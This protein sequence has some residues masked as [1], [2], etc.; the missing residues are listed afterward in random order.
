MYPVAVPS[1]LKSPAPSVCAAILKQS[2]SQ[3]L[4]FNVLEP[5]AVSN[6]NSSAATVQLMVGG[7]V[8]AV[9]GLLK[10]GGVAPGAA[11]GTGAYTHTRAVVRL[12]PT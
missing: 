7:M 10:P 6:S 1:R 12:Y 8:L 2:L 9:G 5:T 3:L 11:P 4:L